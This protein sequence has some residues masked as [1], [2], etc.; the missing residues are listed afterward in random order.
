MIFF[1]VGFSSDET[2]IILPALAESVQFCRLDPGADAGGYYH[3]LLLRGKCCFWYEAPVHEG[4]GNSLQRP[5]AQGARLLHHGTL[6][7]LR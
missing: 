6:T 3:E 1:S 7:F 4:Q 2:N 5:A